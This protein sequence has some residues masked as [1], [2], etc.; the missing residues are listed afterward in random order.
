M[1]HFQGEKFKQLFLIQFNTFFTIGNN[2]RFTKDHID[3]VCKD[4]RYPE[5]FFVDLIFDNDKNIQSNNFEDQVVKWKNI[6]SDFIVKGYKN[7]AKTPIYSSND[8]SVETKI[9]PLIK[10]ENYESNNENKN[11]ANMTSKR[12]FDNNKNQIEN[13][14]YDHHKN[15]NE[16]NKEDIEKKINIGINN[17]DFGMDHDEE[18]SH[19]I[20]T[21]TLEKANEILQKFTKSNNDNI[22]SNEDEEEED[23]DDYIKNLENKA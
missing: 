10:E 8:N 4:L 6:I 17:L 23:L 7:N 20:T 18:E 21:N 5:E 14:I 22:V 19:N 11:Y 16:G 12:D 2:L 13:S 1:L 15:K 9:Y 3:G